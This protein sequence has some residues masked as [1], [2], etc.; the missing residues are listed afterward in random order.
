VSSETLK[1][2]SPAAGYAPGEQRPLGGYA[3]LTAMFGVMLGGFSVWARRTGR[4]LPE[5]FEAGDLALIAVATHKASRLIAK[6]R[7]TSAVRAPFTRFEEEGGPGEVEE[8]ARGSGLR[9][10]IGELVICPYCLSLWIAA[11]F[12]AGLVLAPR[13]TRWL[14]SVLAAVFVS[15]LLQM[16]YKRAGQSL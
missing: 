16:L 7:V 14:A 12:A 3:A 5:R 2:P 6:D 11:G 8:Q 4:Q 1:R 13:A 10:A 9:R 15:D